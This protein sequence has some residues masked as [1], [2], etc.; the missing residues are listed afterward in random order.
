MID[1]SLYHFRLI[2]FQQPPTR[3]TV[4][5]F[6]MVLGNPSI[7]ANTLY[8]K[9]DDYF[10]PI[11]MTV[12]CNRFYPFWEAFSI[13]FPRA[14][15]RPTNSIVFISTGIHPPIAELYSFFPKPIDKFDITNLIT[16]EPIK[17]DTAGA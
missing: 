2:H 8:L 10:N 11:F 6:G 3:T 4:D 14:Y 9:P 12:V 13:N 1:D 16:I 7:C 15:L 17:L 5:P